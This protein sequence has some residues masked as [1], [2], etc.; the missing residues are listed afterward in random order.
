MN[1]DPPKTTGIRDP[2]IGR[3]PAPAAPTRCRWSPQRSS[4]EAAAGCGQL[5]RLPRASL[6]TAALGAASAGFYTL[7]FGAAPLIA[8]GITNE[9][10]GYAPITL[11]CIVC[12]FV[13]AALAGSRRN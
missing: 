8:A 13:S 10:S 5:C 12:F 6:R 3:G 11:F 2:A 9:H 4:R 7:G 1:A